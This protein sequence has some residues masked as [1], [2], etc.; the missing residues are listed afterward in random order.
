MAATPM[1][2]WKWPT[3][4][5]VSWKYRSSA[6]WPRKMPLMP[7]VTNRL[8]KPSE[9]IMAVSKWI[10]PPQSVPIQLKVLMAEGTPM[11]MVSTRERHRRVRVHAAHE[12]VVA[13]DQEAEEA[14]AQDGVHHRF[15]AE[16]RLAREGGEQ[17]RSHAHA[18]QNRDV[19]FGVAEEPEE[20]LPQQRRAALVIGDDLIADHQAAR[21]EETGARRCGRESAAG[22]R[23]AARRNPAGRGWQ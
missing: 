3:T 7:P 13:P 22:R 12:H 10:L 15:V 9:N 2:M 11:H 8:T 5:Y 18:R 20:V 4:K 16:D 6:G 23:P 17:V 19:D 1:I 21:D 14:D